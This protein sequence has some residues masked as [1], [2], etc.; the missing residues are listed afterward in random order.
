[1][2]IEESDYLEAIMKD[3]RLEP[4]EYP[5]PPVC[6]ICGSN[7]YKEIY[8]GPE[9]V[10][11]CDDCVEW[12]PAEEWWEEL[13]IEGEEEEYDWEEENREEEWEED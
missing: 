12:L 6:P 1:M 4:P 10:V 2:F 9:G 8:L 11:G 5:E 13:G 3:Y 7:F